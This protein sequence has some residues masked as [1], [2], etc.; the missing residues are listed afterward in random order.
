MRRI[1]LACGV[2]CALIVGACGTTQ[3]TSAVHDDLRASARGIV[4]V[5][6]VGAR[7]LTDRDQDA[8][9]DTVAGLCGARVWTRSE[10]A[11]HDAARGADR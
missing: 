10:C 11:R 4:G 7:G 5:S 3:T 1:G 8:I 9:D 6:L 2:G